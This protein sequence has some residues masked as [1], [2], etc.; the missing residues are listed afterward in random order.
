MQSERVSEEEGDR[1]RESPQR[2]KFG[3]EAR[4]QMNAC[5]CVSVGAFSYVYYVEPC[6]FASDYWIH[7]CCCSSFS[8]HFISFNLIHLEKR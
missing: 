5:V 4:Q 2:Y 8:F 3:N 7:V 6:V 1:E